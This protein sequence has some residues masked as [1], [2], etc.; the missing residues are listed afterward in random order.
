MIKINNINTLLSFGTLD[1]LDNTCKT[2]EIAIHKGLL[3][4]NE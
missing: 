4:E 1:T 2:V 3:R